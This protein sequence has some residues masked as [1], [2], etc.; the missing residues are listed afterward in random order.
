MAYKVK[1]LS[2]G[3][4]AQIAQARG[5]KM[6]DFRCECGGTFRRIGWQEMYRQRLGAP[7]AAEA[8]AAI[9]RETGNTGIGWGDSRL[10]HAVAERIG[11]PSNGPSTEKL[12][13][14]KIDRT[15]RGVLVKGFTSYPEPGLGRVRRYSLPDLGTDSGG[16]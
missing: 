10:L 14:G 16:Q 7:S 12:V 1:C 11:L 9:L 6:S 8:A 5:L 13:L 4:H 2:C 15:H 3:V